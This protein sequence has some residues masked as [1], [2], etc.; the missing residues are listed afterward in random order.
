MEA[1]GYIM[2]SYKWLISM[3]HWRENI[4]LKLCICLVPHLRKNCYTC[5]LGQASVLYIVSKVFF[6]QRCPLSV[7]Q[8]RCSLLARCVRTQLHTDTHPHMHSSAFLYSHI[9]DLLPQGRR[10]TLWLSFRYIIRALH[11]TLY[12]YKPIVSDLVYS[13]MDTAERTEKWNIWI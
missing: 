12:S 7:Q 11:W 10:F 1:G 4:L 9:L 13:K 5:S 6:A 3:Q 8:R 2:K